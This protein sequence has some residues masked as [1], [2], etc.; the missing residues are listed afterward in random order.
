MPIESLGRFQIGL[1]LP[2]YMMAGKVIVTSRVD[3]ISNIIWN[4]EFVGTKIEI[5]K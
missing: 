3:A 4:K 5:I 2:E 1:V